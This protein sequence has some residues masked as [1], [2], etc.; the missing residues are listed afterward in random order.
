MAEEMHRSRYD[1]TGNPETEYV[2]AAR[3][4]LK[5][6]PGI[7]DRTTLERA[8]EK[9]LARAYERL[10]REVRKDTPVDC[11]LI[12]RVHPSIFGELYSWAGKWRTVWI[13]KPGMTWPAPDFLDQHMQEFE[14]QVLRKHS[15]PTLCD[16]EA[17]CR[18]IA[19]IQGEFL[20]IHPFREGNARTI[21]LTTN[22]LAAQTGRRPLT[23]DATPSGANAYIAAAKAAFARDYAPLT[24]IIRAAMMS[25]H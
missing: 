25:S 21:K 22:L 11:A 24:E 17:F 9:A 23:Y 1:T 4:V 15:P 8:E 2:D 14:R 3:T 6:S 18:A 12:R 5:N 20:V 13:S 19:E 16:N 10:M 7:A